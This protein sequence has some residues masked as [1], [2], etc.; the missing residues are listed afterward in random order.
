MFSIVLKKEES[1]EQL[2]SLFKRFETKE[3][4]LQTHNI[5]ESHMKSA[6]VNYTLN[7]FLDFFGIIFI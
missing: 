7:V 4:Y 1:Y 3:F 5:E 2:I 6:Y